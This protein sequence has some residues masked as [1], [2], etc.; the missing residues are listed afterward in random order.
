[1]C[2][3]RGFKLNAVG[4]QRREE[5]SWAGQD[6][7]G[8]PGGGASETSPSGTFFLGEEGGLSGA[9]DQYLCWQKAPRAREPKK[10]RG[11]FL[12]VG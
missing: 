9:R 8:L 4:A 11:C 1:M 7:K 12:S 6:Y 10:L 2:A 3:L 5:M